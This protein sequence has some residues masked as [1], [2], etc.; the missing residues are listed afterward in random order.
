MHLIER[1]AERLR[2]RGAEMTHE[3]PAETPGAAAPRWQAEAAATVSLAVLQQAGLVEEGRGRTRISEEFRVAESRLLRLVL[4][5][6]AA[7]EPAA[8][9]IMVTSG[10][11]G[12]G[13]TFSALNLAA[14]FA[15]FA[16]RRV[17]LVDTDTKQQSLSRLLDLHERPGFLDLANPARTAADLTVPTEIP[18]L[19][20]LPRGNGAA[21]LATMPG[22]TAM[23]AIVHRIE[24][25]L[26]GH[27]IVLDTAPCLSTSDASAL[28]HAVGHI[29]LVVEAER[30][31][32]GE[33]QASID[34]VRICPSIVLM[35]NKTKARTSYSFGA[36]YGLDYGLEPCT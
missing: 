13:K 12:E 4:A 24:Q 8:N 14:S 2:Q 6:Q 30:T 26:P 36:Y 31:Q 23:D 18:E 28:A 3:A 33:L 34:L 25:A 27:I 7:G 20:I 32:R 9:L 5:A 35:L 29:V 19:H 21:E 11:P 22:A 17:L 15:R 10:R 1:A 16:R